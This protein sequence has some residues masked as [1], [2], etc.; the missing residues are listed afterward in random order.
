MKRLQIFKPGTFVASNGK[1]YTFTEVDLIAVARGYDP[2]KHEAPLCVGHPKD[3]APAY[4]WAKSAAFAEGSLEIEPHQ[5]E[6]Q[7]AELVAA[8]RFK[9]RSA[10]FYPPDSKQNPTPGAWYLRHVF[11][12]IAALDAT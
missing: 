11:S 3:D 10:A 12:P 7:F 1:S 6:P 2:A 8:G 4:G 5:V 9:K